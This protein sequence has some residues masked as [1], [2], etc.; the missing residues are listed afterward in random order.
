MTFIIQLFSPID[1][2]LDQTYA[3]TSDSGCSSASGVVSENHPRIGLD[4]HH[5]QLPRFQCQ[6]QYR[7]PYV[8]SPY[9]LDRLSIVPRKLIGEDGVANLWLSSDLE[10]VR[11]YHRG[12]HLVGL[13]LAREVLAWRWLFLGLGTIIPHRS[14]IHTLEFFSTESKNRRMDP[15][16][17]LR[18][19]CRFSHFLV[20]T[21]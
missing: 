5:S 8:P 2:Y 12:I 15:Y 10:T 7:E 21:S 20:G 6:F 19:H 13:S 9:Q 14:A 4:A 3:L 16:S 1:I 11:F 17:A 18:S